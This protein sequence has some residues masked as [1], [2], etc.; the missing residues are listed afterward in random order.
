MFGTLADIRNE[1]RVRLGLPDRGDSGDTRLNTFINMAVRQMWTELPKQLLYEETRIMAEPSFSTGTISTTADNRVMSLPYGIGSK[2]PTAPLATDGSVRGRTLEYEY[3]GRF[4]YRRIQDVYT[5]VVPSVQRIVLDSPNATGAAAGTEMSNFRIFTEEYPY[6]A[7]AQEIVEV[8]RDPD[9]SPF[10]ILES[11]FLADLTNYRNSVG[12]RLEGQPEYYARGSFYQL[13]SPHYAPKVRVIQVVDKDLREA[14]GFD[15]NASLQTSYGPAGTF[16]Y[17]VIHVWGR[18][19]QYLN[20]NEGL[21]LPFY[22]SAP[23][24]AS[25]QVSTVWQG[26]AI[27]ITTPDIDYVYGYGPDTTALSYHHHGVEKFFFRR[28][29]ATEPGGGGS[30]H[31]DS[32]ENDN[33]YYLWRVTEGHVTRTL[34]RGDDDPV[35]RRITLKATNGHFHIRFD[36]SISDETPILL[37]LFR[38]PPQL[39]FDTDT[40]RLPPDCYDALYALVAS[41]V[42]GDRDGEPSR[43]AFYMDEYKMHLTRLRR[44]YN[45]AGHQVGRFGNGI[46]ARGHRFGPSRNRRIKDITPP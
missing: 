38:R 17:I 44:T 14:W 6:P 2:N 45:V 28:R 27:E 31:G 29:I 7:D 10:P 34:D 3:D 5:V 8:I 32:V 4:Y 19:K 40:P 41:M 43:K 24:R 21:L 13:P 18:Q 11:T 35:D 15:S 23:S 46:S 22:Q 1:V 20:S 42:V 39:T 36:R 12:F 25:G 16:E 33:T 37:R 30:V 26:G 9:N